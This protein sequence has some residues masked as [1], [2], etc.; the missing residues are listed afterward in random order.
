MHGA[1][2]IRDDVQCKCVALGF[3]VHWVWLGV[4]LH[5]SLQK[6]KCKTGSSTSEVL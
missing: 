5:F 2:L 3:A 6:S 1:A 4:S